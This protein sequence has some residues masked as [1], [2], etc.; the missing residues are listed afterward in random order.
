MLCQADAPDAARIPPADLLGVTVILLSCHFR[1]KE[2]IRVGYYDNRGAPEHWPPAVA[3]WGRGG[4]G[5]LF[6]GWG[7]WWW[8]WWG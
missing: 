2:F 3:A 6:G 1:D 8:W 7:W 4:G 5:G